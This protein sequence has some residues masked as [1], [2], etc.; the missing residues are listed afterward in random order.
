MHLETG[1]MTFADEQLDEQGMALRRGTVVVATRWSRRMRAARA[2]GGGTAE[3][4]REARPPRTPP[5]S[6]TRSA[7]RGASR[8]TTGPGS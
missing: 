1:L 8:S 3:R 4:R 6:A 7:T 2:V 5:G